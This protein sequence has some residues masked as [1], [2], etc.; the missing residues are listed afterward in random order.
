[1]VMNEENII[2]DDEGPKSGARWKLAFNGASNAMGHRIEVY[3]ISPNNG[4]TPFTTRLCFDY[5]KN[6]E[7]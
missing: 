5:M 3:L 7:E 1:M 6:M 4:Y 2:G